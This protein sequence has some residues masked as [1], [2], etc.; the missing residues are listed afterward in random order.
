MNIFLML[1]IYTFQLKAYRK[2]VAKVTDKAVVD[3]LIHHVT[4]E[5]GGC[6]IG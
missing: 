1:K 3:V 2:V 6:G 5:F 4:G